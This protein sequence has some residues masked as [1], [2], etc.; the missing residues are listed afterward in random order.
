LSAF[1]FY[2]LSR[3][4]DKLFFYGLI[5][6]INEHFD[7]ALFSPDHHRLIAHTAHHV[8]RVHRPAPKG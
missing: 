3:I 8:K 2:I 7:L 1:I 4:I 5:L 6:T